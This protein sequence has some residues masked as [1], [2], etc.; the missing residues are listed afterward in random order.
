MTT[1]I[2]DLKPGIQRIDMTNMLDTALDFLTEAMCFIFPNWEKETKSRRMT[3]LEGT[4][5][6][7]NV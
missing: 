7:W 5:R 2:K 1:V 6:I 4:F 3:D